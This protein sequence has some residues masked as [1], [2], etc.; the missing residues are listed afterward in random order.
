MTARSAARRMST[1][2]GTWS[3]YP[4]AQQRLGVQQGGVEIGKDQLVLAAQVDLDLI[5]RLAVF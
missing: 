2:A 1:V 3:R 4:W 5:L